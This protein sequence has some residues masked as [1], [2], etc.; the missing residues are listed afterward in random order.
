M[1]AKSVDFPFGRQCHKKE[2][3]KSA[4]TQKGVSECRWKLYEE[5]YEKFQQLS[6]PSV[7]C[8][9]GFQKMFSHC[10]RK[11]DIIGKSY[12]TVEAVLKLILLKIFGTKKNNKNNK[13]INIL[14]KVLT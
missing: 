11:I 6:K 3:L 1:L 8:T 4:N 2:C 10:T 13:A 12:H 14:Q 7:M 9:S 5:I